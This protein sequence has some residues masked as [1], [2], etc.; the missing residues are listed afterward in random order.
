MSQHENT[1]CHSLIAWYGW[2][3]LYVHRNCRLIRDRS[4]GRP[5]W[6]SHNSK[7]LMHGIII[8]VFLGVGWVGGV[9]SCS[10]LNES[11]WKFKLAQL[12]GRE[13]VSVF[14]TSS[15]FQV[16]KSQVSQRETSHVVQQKDSLI[17]DLEAEARQ[18]WALYKARSFLLVWGGGG[19]GPEARQ[20]RALYKA[21]SFLFSC[22]LLLF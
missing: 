9:F 17:A 11:T 16:E 2:V 21:G 6:L 14:L 22:L 5:P 15:V 10:T 1:N 18:V 13:S 4:P 7:A 12:Y 8:S 20:V 3:L 19:R